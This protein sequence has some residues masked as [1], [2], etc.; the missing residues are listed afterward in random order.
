MAN[1]SKFTAAENKRLKGLRQKAKMKSGA[2]NLQ[3]KVKDTVE[4]TG[5]SASHRQYFDE[6]GRNPFERERLFNPPV[7]KKKG[8]PILMSPRKQMA[9]GGKVHK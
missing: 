5:K 7:K 6:L 1:L 2:S 4:K 3:G 9:C 8:G